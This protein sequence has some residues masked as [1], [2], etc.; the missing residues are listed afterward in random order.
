MPEE[1]PNEE[2]P[3]P[4]FFVDVEYYFAGKIV[5]HTFST[6]YPNYRSG[7]S[8]SLELIPTTREKTRRP[9]QEFT[10]HDY[11]VERVHHKVQEGKGS[12]YPSVF[13]LEVYL[14]KPED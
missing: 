10:V 13:G 2:I 4:K 11:F 9:A 3:F 12:E 6:I 5:Y 1:T 7:D 8:L 14:R